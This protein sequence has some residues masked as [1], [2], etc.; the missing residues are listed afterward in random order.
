M[1]TTAKLV[2]GL[3][4]HPAL[5]TGTVSEYDDA[6]HNTLEGILTAT[7]PAL[8]V[9]TEPQEFI[10]PDLYTTDSQIT[11][12]VVVVQERHRFD[13]NIL[14]KTASVLM[15]V[16][17][18]LHSQSANPRISCRKIRTGR[19]EVFH[20]LETDIWIRVTGDL[21]TKIGGN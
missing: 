15:Q 17:R 1:S 6:E 11:V 18:S 16:I 19:D 9:D 14:S 21:A 5:I 12:T 3:T 10:F 7:K 20:V 13:S 2:A 8:I 4:N